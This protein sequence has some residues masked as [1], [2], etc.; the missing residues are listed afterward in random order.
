MAYFLGGYR[1][2][3]K[4][5]ALEAARPS[6]RDYLRGLLEQGKIVC[7][8]PLAD[9]EEGRVLYHAESRD[10]VQRLIA[11]DPYVTLEGATP[12]TPLEW[13]VTIHGENFA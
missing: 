3:K 11:A 10:E 5:E 2:D 9:G 7:A 8:G 1:Y 12:M 6:H 13:S 4:T